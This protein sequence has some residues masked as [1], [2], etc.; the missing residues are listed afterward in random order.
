MSKTIKLKA[1]LEENYSGTMLGGVVSKTP[2]HNDISLAKIVKEKYGDVTEEK[3]DVEGLTTEIS[4]YNSLGESIF[5][6]S[7][8]TQI[9]EKLSW[10]AKQTQSHTL[11]ETEDWFDKI[12]VNRNMKELTGLSNNFSK[13]ASEA[14][15]LQERMSAL[16]EDM[17]NILGR[18]YEIDET[19]SYRH[20]DELDDEDNDEVKEVEG[21]KAEYEKFFRAALK[22]FGVSEPDK[23]PDDKKK[24]FYN[25]IDA[26][27]KGDNESD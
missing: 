6:K 8:I 9:A 1:L 27:W 19:K 18:Y 10:I 3:I 4:K 17:G 11:R 21:D 20:G 22:K 2:F 14:Q 24:E 23:L 16:Y 5:G 15:S 12:T 26:N 13:I 25:Y 7:N